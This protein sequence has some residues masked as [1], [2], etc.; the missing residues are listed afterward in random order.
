M[1]KSQRLRGS[2]I[3]GVVRLV[4]ECRELWAD[5]DAWQP[6]LARGAARLTGTS[7]GMFTES[8]LAPDRRSV[9]VFDEVDLGWRD[10]QARSY[11]RQ[12]HQKHPDRVAFSPRVY[13]LAGRAL[14]HPDR[15][16]TALRSEIR[17]DAEWYRSAMYHDY[18]RPAHIDGCIVSFA[19]NPHTGNLVTLH[20][21]QDVTDPAPTVQAKA[22]ISLLNG[23]V[24]PLVGTEL[25]SRRQR[26]LH[27]LSPRLRQVLLALLEGDS[28]K[29]VAHR[30]GLARPTVHEYVGV[31][32]RHFAVSSRGELMAYFLHRRPAA[33]RN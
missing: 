32:Y 6:H 17:P 11:R 33:T 21:A 14:E 13:R 12:M 25:A 4:G 8:W 27:K 29:Q 16:A 30:L 10:E 2:E 20:V 18:Y 7:V 5:A 1:A 19:V 24:A 26:G 31:L 15:V 3:T 28:E 9:T 23:L 22:V